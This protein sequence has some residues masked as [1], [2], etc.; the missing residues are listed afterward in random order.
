MKASP[1]LLMLALLFL[2]VWLV[3]SAE[4]DLGGVE[5]R[6]GA[7]T[8]K[9]LIGW[10]RGVLEIAP[11]TSDEATYPED[12]F[13]II[14]R[15]GHVSKTPLS[16]RQLAELFGSA[17]YQQATAGRPKGLFRLLNITSWGGLAWFLIG[18]TGQLAFFGRMFVQWMVSE[19]KGE[20]V[21]TPA[22]WWF[23]LVGGVMLFTYFVW[24]M[25]L[26]GVLGQSTGIVIYA[27]NLQLIRRRGEILT[28][29]TT[30]S[31]PS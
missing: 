12:T 29:P 9:L 13:R 30:P 7:E 26:V 24:R 20:S 2:G 15:D 1:V 17:V 19:K 4:A 28:P 8:Q 23:S 18:V 31:K 25:D 6:P 3:W 27:R 10:T 11:S 21:V 22:F 5:L 16:G 14:T